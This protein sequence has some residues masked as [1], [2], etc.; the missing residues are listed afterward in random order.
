MNFKGYSSGISYIEQTPS[1]DVMAIGLEDGTIDIMNL[2]YDE[3]KF[4]VGF[5]F[6]DSDGISTIIRCNRFILLQQHGKGSSS[7]FWW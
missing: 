3:V 4:L 7:R 1:V 5:D 6:L 2:K